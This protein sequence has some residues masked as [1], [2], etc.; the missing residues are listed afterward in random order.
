MAEDT[1]AVS[2]GPCKH[3]LRDFRAWVE[4]VW[5]RS[6]RRQYRGLSDAVIRSDRGGRWS[7]RRGHIGLRVGVGPTQSS[8]RSDPRWYFVLAIEACRCR[9]LRRSKEPAKLY[10]RICWS[11]CSTLGR[12]IGDSAILHPS[13]GAEQIQTDH[14]SCCAHE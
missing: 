12:S 14:V 8:T 2:M 10:R 4:I 6:T 13:A 11:R 9:L 1:F 5:S 3:A 7:V